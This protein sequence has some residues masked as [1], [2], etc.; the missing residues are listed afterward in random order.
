MNMRIAIAMLALTMVGACGQGH[1]LPPAR[2]ICHN[3]NCAGPTDPFRDDTV[4]ALAES[5]ALRQDGRPTIDGVEVDFIWYAAQN[6]CLFGHDLNHDAGGPDALVPA[7][8]I[9]AHLRD[10]PLASWNGD[11]F[12]IK[13]ELKSE[14]GANGEAQT[15]EM[16]ERLADC[17]LDAADVIATA[18]RDSNHRVVFLFEVDAEN[19]QILMSRPRWPGTCA[20]DAAEYR[21][22]ASYRARLPHGCR[23]DVLGIE[24]EQVKDGFFT[25]FRDAGVQVLLNMYDVNVQTIHTIDDLMPEFVGTDEAPFIRRWLL[26]HWGGD[27]GIV[28]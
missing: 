15:P 23:A 21:L 18:A 6:R 12:Y 19:D 10:S 27:D 14:V 16:A 9:A 24:V 4:G 11:A 13:M 1:I 2:I 20:G 28:R 7:E 22:T 25:D 3:A 26:A 8:M 5:L 17:A